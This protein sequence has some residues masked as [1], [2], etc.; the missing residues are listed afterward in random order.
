MADPMAQVFDISDSKFSSEKFSP[1][2]PFVTTLIS[3]PDLRLHVSKSRTRDDPFSANLRRWI[4]ILI[5]SLFG[6]LTVILLLTRVND[7]AHHDPFANLERDNAVQ[8]NPK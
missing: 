2:S 4:V 6:M 5:I 1:R 3:S 7:E 8:I